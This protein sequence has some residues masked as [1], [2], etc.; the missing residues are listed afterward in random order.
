MVILGLHRDPWHNSG[1]CILHEKSG[2]LRVTAISQERL[3][4][5]KDSANY[6]DQAIS[7]CLEEA[8]ITHAGECDY[9]ISDYILRPDWEN[10][11]PSK[12]GIRDALS[13]IK[14]TL[15]GSYIR[16]RI[17]PEKV[18]SMNHHLAHAFSAFY[19]S[20]FQNAAVLIIDGHGSVAGNKKIGAEERNSRFETQSLYY[21]DIEK[22]IKLI[23]SSNRP[24][25]GM[26]YSSF[27]RFLGFQR[28]QDG[29]TMGL[30]PYGATHEKNY[31]DFSSA[32][33][34][35]IETDYSEY[36]DI[37]ADNGRWVLI[38]GLEPCVERG[39]QTNSYYSRIAWEVQDELEKAMLFLADYAKTRTGADYL[40][41]AGGVGL[42]SVANDKIRKSGIFKDIWIQP[43]SSDVGIPLGCALYGYYEL[44]K[45]RKSWKINNASL[46]RFYS[47]ESILNAIGKYESSVYFE[48]DADYRTAARLLAEGNIIGW[49]QG[50]SEYGP[51]AL[52]NRSILVDPRKSENK[53]ILNAKVK[54]RESF[55]PF[56]P[57][58]LLE[59][60]SEYFEMDY[61]SPFMLMVP[62]AL[63]KAKNE[64]PAVVHIDGTGRVQ[65]V[66]KR[67][68]DLYYDLINAF[69]ELTGV[70]VLLN[71]S[72]NVAGEPIVETPEDAIDTFLK[73]A[74][75][76]LIM[77]NFIVR[78][79][80]T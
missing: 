18:I 39:A 55:R 56:A 43:G 62:K 21:A 65:T 52:G 42:N 22:G 67:D 16:N 48:E 33:Y 24:G 58:I 29:K 51:R 27:T 20:G 1:A 15:K 26:L 34:N 72:F 76:Y 13:F 49:F 37:W 25:L 78:K 79:R 45:G 75:D 6:P 59:K 47:E 71:T 19:P 23:E 32:K 30:A 53:N 41:I 28:L 35:G 50:G 66:T 77:N 69:Y 63:T 2:E 70:P 74:I 57:S 46:G 11:R 17:A 10:D 36:V 31:I 68:N 40:C 3:D 7:Y 60:A 12:K 5:I 44:A 54:F 9:I 61:P 64:I 73:S 38:E 80:G 4:R 8:G 14:R